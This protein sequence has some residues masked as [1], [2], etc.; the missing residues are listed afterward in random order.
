M[1]DTQNSAKAIQNLSE[2]MQRSAEIFNDIA[3]TYKA[4]WDQLAKTITVIW[5]E[6]MKSSIPAK[7]WHLYKH[8]KKARV[9]KKYYN[10][11]IKLLSEV[12]HDD[13]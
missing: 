8:A 11:I 1:N 9:R 6:I 10:R 3:E 7:W 4:V 5:E 2:A 13:R 12:Q